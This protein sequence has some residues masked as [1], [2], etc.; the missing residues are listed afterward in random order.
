MRAL[1][2]IARCAHL[3]HARAGHAIRAE[4]WARFAAELARIE[5]SS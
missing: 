4:F 1:S 3:R 2:L 5:A